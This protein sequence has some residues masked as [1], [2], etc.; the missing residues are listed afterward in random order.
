MTI[1]TKP[2]N[3]EEAVLEPDLPIVD[4]HQQLWDRE[5]SRYLLEDYLADAESDHATRASVYIE[6]GAM[7]RLEGPRPYTCKFPLFRYSY[8]PQGGTI[9]RF[10]SAVRL[11]GR[12]QRSGVLSVERPAGGGAEWRIGHRGGRHGSLSTALVLV[13]GLALSLLVGRTMS[14]RR[15]WPGRMIVC[16]S[17]G[18]G[19]GWRWH[20][21]S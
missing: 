14:A 7:W 19:A 5:G 9:V 3:R 1:D 6:S 4:A 8:V 2:Q 16:A 13:V 17:A 12:V 21:G 11:S 18:P 20:P 15:R 10:V